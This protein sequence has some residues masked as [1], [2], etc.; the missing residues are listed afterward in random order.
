[1]WAARLRHDGGASFVR[2]TERQRAAGKVGEQKTKRK[3]DPAYD[4]EGHRQA[5]YDYEGHRQATR[6]HRHEPPDAHSVP[7][8]PSATSAGRWDVPARPTFKRAS[9]E[10][11]AAACEDKDR[12]LRELERDYLATTTR[13]SNASRLK[14]WGRLHEK[15]FGSHVPVFPLLPAGVKAVMA[16]LKKG[17]YKDACAY[18]SAARVESRDLGHIEHPLVGHVAAATRAKRSCLRGQGD[19]KQTHALPVSRLGELPAATEP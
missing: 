8:A 19:A 14:L 2:L 4:Y 12:A 15:W 3:R 10:V 17:G 6:S 7:C 1:M 16:C 5:A 11:A 13:S 9:A 18:L